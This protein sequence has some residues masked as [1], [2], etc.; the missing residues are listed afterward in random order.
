MIYHVISWIFIV[1]ILI[2]ILGPAPSWSA[3][4]NTPKYR[5]RTTPVVVFNAA[6][7][8]E[9]RLFNDV[10]L[11]DTDS[12]VRSSDVSD[13][14]SDLLNIILTDSDGEQEIRPGNNSVLVIT[15][16]SDVV[17]SGPVLTE[18]AESNEEIRPGNKSSDV[19]SVATSL[20]DPVESGSPVSASTA[21]VGEEA[22]EEPLTDGEASGH[23]DEEE[24][25]STYFV[26]LVF[27]YRRGEKKVPEGKVVQAA[28]QVA[29]AVAAVKKDEA[30]EEEGKTAE[31]AIKKKTGMIVGAVLGTLG[32]V[33][34]AGFGIYRFF[35]R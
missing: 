4:F 23:E 30:K 20:T 1:S 34:A 10:H 31:V 16:L 11:L 28:A 7:F 9:A 12:L 6:N 25:Y 33:G 26:P 2:S 15:R 14:P 17:N 13:L 21:S 22:Q 3:L 8:P 5:L 27:P 18:L 29:A 24:G 35:T 19:L 32:A